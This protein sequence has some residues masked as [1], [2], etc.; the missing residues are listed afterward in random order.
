MVCFAVTTGIGRGYIEL[1]IICDTKPLAE[2]HAADLR[3][4]GC[5]GVK[6]RKF[7]HEADAYDW[8]EK[9]R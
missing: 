6:I 9:M 4:M 1:D 3:K 5:D 7:N 8:A 2:R